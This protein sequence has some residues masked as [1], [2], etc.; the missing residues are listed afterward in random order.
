MVDLN[1]AI[2]TWANDKRTDQ[3]PVTVVDQ[4]TGFNTGTDTLDGVHPNAAGNRRIAERL[5][6]L[7]QQHRS[8]L[9]L[10]AAASQLST[11]SR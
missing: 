2:P 8:E 3:S 1:A 9:R 4:W 11:R 5:F 10:D 6:E 7:M